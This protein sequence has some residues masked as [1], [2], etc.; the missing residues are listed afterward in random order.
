[1]YNTPFFGLN[2]PWL[3]AAILGGHPSK[4]HS[5]KVLISEPTLVWLIDAPSQMM[6][7]NA[8]GLGL[9][10]VPSLAIRAERVNDFDTPRFGI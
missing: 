1:M 6:V 4:Q 10:L 7:T 9:R 8:V 2:L 5:T 3:T